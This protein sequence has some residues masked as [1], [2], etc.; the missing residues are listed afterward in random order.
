MANEQKPTVL[1]VDDQA[2][3]IDVLSAILKDHYK[4]KVA[5]NGKKALEIAASSP[6]PDLILLDV[7]MPEMDGYEVCR[8]LKSGKKT[9]E[10]PVIF[11]T[12]LSEVQDET[13]GF[14]VGA[15]D[16]IT[17]PVSPP[18]VLARAGTQLALSNAKAEAEQLL[19]KTLLG[20][21]KLLTG[22]L[23]IVSPHAFKQAHRLARYAAGVAEQLEIENAWNVKLA[24]MLSH[25]GCI[26]ISPEIVEKAYLDQLLKR[27][28]QA[29]IDSH[30][31]IGRTMISH[32]PRME[33]VAE[34][35]ARQAQPL[36][37]EDLKQ[38]V[39]DWDPIVLGGQILKAVISFDR[40]IAAGVTPQSAAARLSDHAKEYH[41]EVSKALHAVQAGEAKSTAHR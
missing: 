16:Y 34:M 7:K 24:A 13:E 28:E 10:I 27:E 5:I 25:I 32:I 21:V 1:V 17:K 9:A 18:V 2:E 3:N 33:A 26:T 8:R 36:K 40:L 22:L 39:K 12:A 41:P 29:I 37:A 14:S 38:D 4:V 6:P 23:S 11:V 15:V 19:S 30:P 20:S 31:E 35:I